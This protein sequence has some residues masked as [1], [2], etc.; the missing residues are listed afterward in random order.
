M[1]LHLSNNEIITSTERDSESS[2]CEIWFEFNYQLFQT[3]LTLC[4]IYT[5]RSLLFLI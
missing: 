2:P 5:P 1:Y 3:N 4:I